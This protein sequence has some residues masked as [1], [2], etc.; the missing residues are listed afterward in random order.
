MSSI[1]NTVL[2]TSL[3]DISKKEKTTT[4]KNEETA[5]S[6]IKRQKQEFFT[7]LTTQLKNQDPMS[8]M[9][10][11][12]MTRQVFAINQVEQQLETNRILDEIKKTFSSVQS[13]NYLNYIGKIVS[14]P[15]SEVMVENGVGLFNYDIGEEAASAVI[16]IHDK[17]TGS[18]V[19]SQNVPFSMG[20]HSFQWQRPEH[21]QDGMYKFT[22]LP[23]KND[24]ELA[25]F[26]TYAS[27]KVGAVLSD[28]GEYF[29]D[30]NGQTVSTN[31]VSKITN[32]ST[33]TDSLLNKINGGISDLGERIKNGIATPMT[34]PM[35]DF[36]DPKLLDAIK[37]A[38]IPNVVQ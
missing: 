29:F 13:S 17:N 24:D 11:N 23:Y 16:Q 33:I 25:K 30:V 15:G 6:R 7:L 20:S 19:H 18:L 22:V 36:G 14:Y 37:N 35:P 28:K 27:G 9:D 8:P 10:S 3:E 38:I 1:N 31:D 34:Q 12:E 5:E 26:R 4:Y 32:P 2:K 21:L